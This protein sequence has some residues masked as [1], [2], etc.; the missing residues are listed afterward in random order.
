MLHFSILFMI[1]DLCM[2]AL[3]MLHNLMFYLYSSKRNESYDKKNEYVFGVAPCLAALQAGRRQ[4]FEI[5]IRE[6]GAQNTERFVVALT[7]FCV[8]LLGN[9]YTPTIVIAAYK[10]MLNYFC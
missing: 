1:L 5:Y 7:S 2:H 10:F 3:I 6:A 8:I 9:N 4:V